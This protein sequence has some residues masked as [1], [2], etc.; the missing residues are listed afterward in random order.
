[1]GIHHHS[2]DTRQPV[3]A[4]LHV[5][6][7]D[8]PRW[9]LNNTHD[10]YSQILFLQLMDHTIQMA[11]SWVERR[12]NE[13]NSELKPNYQWKCTTH[14]HLHG[15]DD[16]KLQARQ[17]RAAAGISTARSLQPACWAP[18]HVARIRL[19]STYTAV[20]VCKLHAIYVTS[21]FGS[22]CFFPFN[23]NWLLHMAIK[24]NLASGKTPV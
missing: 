5:S 15:L 1:M 20:A 14:L 7:Q 11:K 21:E 6:M 2:F 13:V 19:Q 12:T 4:L 8:V 16:V 3:F 23:T 24:T 9:L 10:N 18:Q 22:C 17:G